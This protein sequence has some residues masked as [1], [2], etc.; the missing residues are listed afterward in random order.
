MRY[1]D[2]VSKEI[3]AVVIEGRQARKIITFENFSARNLRAL[4]DWT[5]VCDGDRLR[6]VAD[7]ESNIDS[8]TSPDPNIDLK[9]AALAV[10]SYRPGSRNLAS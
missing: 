2:G 10:T 9:P 1:A 6:S 3:D 5:L 7:F 4:Q 8:Q